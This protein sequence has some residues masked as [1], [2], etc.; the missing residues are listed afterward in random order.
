MNSEKEKKPQTENKKKLVIS[1][2][3]NVNALGREINSYRECPRRYG[4]DSG[5]LKDVEIRLLHAVGK[6]GDL[7][8]K[9]LAKSLS[10][11]KGAISIMVTRLVNEGYLVKSV[12]D[13]DSRKQILQLT[14]RGRMVYETYS[15]IISDYY[16][17]LSKCLTDYTE[18]DI[19]KCNKLIQ[20]IIDYWTR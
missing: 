3:E 9:E 5:T 14:D 11:T 4:E 7:S 17:D 13:H 16:A 2:V 20:S 10:R 1:L 18:E 19:R 6:H 15:T 12:D 8:N